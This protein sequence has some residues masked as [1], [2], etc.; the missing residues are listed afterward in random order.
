VDGNDTWMR[1][2]GGPFT[3][4]DF[5]QLYASLLAD[6]LDTQMR[7]RQ[8]LAIG[9]NAAAG[10][11]PK[12]V[13]VI[14]GDGNTGAE[15][16]IT[17]GEPD[18]FGAAAEVISGTH[19]HI[20][21]R[22]WEVFTGRG[23][24]LRE[25][26]ETRLGYARIPITVDGEAVN[27]NPRAHSAAGLVDIDEGGVTG[28]AFLQELDRAVVRWVKD[29]VLI[30][31]ETVDD[32]VP[33]F[34]AVV[35]GESLRKDLSQQEIVRDQ[36]YR[37]ALSA[38]RKAEGRALSKLADEVRKGRVR[39]AE[40]RWIA[41][42]LGAKVLSFG[43]AEAFRPGG[44][45]EPV[46]SAPVFETADGYLLS[47]NQV[48]AVVDRS[49]PFLHADYSLRALMADPESARAAGM[50]LDGH[51]VL[52]VDW[53][54]PERRRWFL[55]QVTGGRLRSVSAQLRSLPRNLATV[56]ET[57]RILVWGR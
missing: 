20:R 10:M 42:V 47:V 28:Y 2:D 9:L 3:L 18:R 53:R 26:L 48:L 38:V 35:H 5:D 23:Q 54:T 51:P 24:R 55:A 56:D 31:S 16:E 25:L 29:G 14:S 13:K 37:N 57:M 27:W 49:E 44:P 32:L 39:L 1:F 30:T 19:V 17:P 21:G 36:A 45:G 33:G 46:A 40:N 15:L 11:K 43:S 52:K 34:T 8:E 50:D 6:T 12:Y 4:E 41:E 22:M 7:A